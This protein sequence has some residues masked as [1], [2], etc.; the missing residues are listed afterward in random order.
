[1][2]NNSMKRKIGENI[3]GGG[4]NIVTPDKLNPE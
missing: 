1:M 4:G 2:G 3:I